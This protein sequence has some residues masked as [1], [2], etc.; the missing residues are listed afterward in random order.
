LNFLK[1]LKKLI[2]SNNTIAKLPESIVELKNLEFLDLS[3]N[4]LDTLPAKLDKLKHFK[5][6]NTI[7]IFTPQERPGFS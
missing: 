2:L 6:L 3:N 1:S 7:F 4:H 5:Y